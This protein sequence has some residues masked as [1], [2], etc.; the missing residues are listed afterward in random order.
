MEKDKEII[1]RSIDKS[2]AP[3]R[4]FLGIKANNGE[5]TVKTEGAF[6]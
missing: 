2:Q 5:R 1:P 3:L 6:I 4:V